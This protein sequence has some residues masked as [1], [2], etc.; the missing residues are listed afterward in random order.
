M[1][2]GGTGEKK[3]DYMAPVLCP[4]VSKFIKGDVQAC[5]T[6]GPPKWSSEAGWPLSSELS[7]SQQTYLP[8]CAQEWQAFLPEKLFLSL[9][10][11]VPYPSAYSGSDSHYSA[12]FGPTSPV[13]VSTFMPKWS[14]VR[15]GPQQ[16]NLHGLH[17]ALTTYLPHTNKQ[18]C[19]PC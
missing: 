8:T 18:P 11:E 13:K 6:S 2:G 9:Q 1:D 5:L 17:E 19:F 7:P 15:P 10:K 4:G 14:T 3:R 16:Q 12:H